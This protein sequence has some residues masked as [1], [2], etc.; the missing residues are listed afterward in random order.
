MVELECNTKLSKISYDVHKFYNLYNRDWKCLAKYVA[1]ECI[2]FLIF[3][4][5]ILGHD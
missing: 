2:E 1:V 4:F 5:K 3:H